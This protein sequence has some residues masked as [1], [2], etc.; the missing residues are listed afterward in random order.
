[1]QKP[2]L[3][4]LSAEFCAPLSALASIA[5]ALCL[6]LPSTAFGQGIVSA[7]MTGTLVD[8]AG[9][10]IGG[11]T[12]TAVHTPTNTTY[13]DI[14]GQNGRFSFTGMP[15][16]GP[17]TVSAVSGTFRIEP[18][19]DVETS[20]GQI[21]DV[22]LVAKEEVVAMEKFVASATRID[23]DG[24]ATGAATV[25]DSRQ[26]LAQPNGGRTFADLFKT[27]PFV[28]LRAF[29]QVE[30]L[31]I[32]SRYN[33]ITL[34]GAKINDSFGLNP[35]GLFSLNNPFSLD[36]IEQFSISLTPYDVRQSG[37][38]GAAMNA[39]SKSGT[40]EFHGSG[41]FV[42]TDHNW[43]GKD[44]SGSTVNTRSL[45][46]ERTYGFTF[47][48][49]I[50]KDR[51]FFFTNFEKYFR[52]S[53]GAT[54][55]GFT[56][57]AAFLDA[58]N[59]R[60]SALPGTPTMGTFGASSVSRLAD[61]KRMAKLDWN[62]TKD[63]RLSVRYS[64]T[65]GT[66]PTFGS[67]NAT[68]F[69]QPAALNNQPSSFTNNTT[70][71]T[72]N[73]YTLDVREKVWAAQLF[74]NWTS[75]FKTQFS[76]S[77]TKQDS[78]RAT[79]VK[80]PEI[81][82][83]NVPGVSS[84]GAT[85]SSGDSFRFGTETSSMGNELHIKTQTMSGSGDYTVKNLTFTGG[86]DHEVSD[87]LNLFRQGSYG[88]FDYWNLADFQADRPFGFARAVI[89][90]G[91]PVADVSRFK[92]TGIF[93]QVKWEPNSRLNA[94]L[95]VRLD[96]I[97]SPIAPPENAPFT[98]AFGVTN[99][100]TI[101]GTSNIEP[102][103]SFNY[104]LDSKRD[105]QVRGGL[106]VYLGRN[107]WVWISNSFG[108]TGVG[109]FNSVYST[110]AATTPNTAAYAGPTLT[111]YLNGSFSNSD[112]AY[113]FDPANPIGATNG[114]GTASS[115]NLIKPGL[116][117]PTVMRG[118][119]AVDHRLPFLDA[120]VSVEYIETNQLDALFVDNMNLRPTTVGI[121]G[122]QRF[123]G[124]ATN[125]P[126]VTNF[127]NV[128][129]TRDVR[130]GASQYTSI[131]L[132]RPFK[133]NWAYTVSLTHG[134][135][136]EAQTLNSSTANSQWQF[137]SVFNQNQVEVARS[138]YEIRDRVQ[139][140]MS[141]RFRFKSDYITTVSL[142]YEG[143]TGQPYSFVYANDFN[144]DGF[145]VNDLV[146]V[147]KS[148]TDPRFD[149]TGLTAAQQYAYFAFLEQSGLSRYGGSYAPRNSFTTEWQNRLD[150]RLV[151]ELPAYRQVKFEVFADFINFGAWLSHH[152]FNYIQ[153]IN[154][155]TGN[156]GLTRA[157]GAATY[158]ASNGLIKPTFN[159]GSTTVLVLDADNNLAFSGSST[160]VPNNGDSRWKITGGIRIKF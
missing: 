123:A 96:Y 97:G 91:L 140:S 155:S 19:T 37:F 40:N 98:N 65:L 148:L 2:F 35:S 128:I 67:Y 66:L 71:F 54:R 13:T 84:S 41:Y 133:N 53:L 94:T 130:K 31:G 60:L 25:L 151:Q 4:S 28:S 112:P 80:F 85:I 1:M 49:P 147:P 118:N 132:D 72:S 135:A 33:T 56:P 111:Q 120:T 159:N 144:N 87:Y 44:V 127:A 29:P 105:T 146:A 50:L 3:K 89:Q 77:N 15:V 117:L 39:V 10:P 126:L 69:S 11:A 102:R 21:T 137:N 36:A 122:R 82:I 43:G 157:F 22:L 78:V 100:G 109:R 61:T 119:I 81:R 27:N 141:R 153:E 73:F 83:M 86:A 7:G 51:L 59:T 142:Y 101:D 38:A 136:T 32:N 8:P 124:N 110:P 107:P 58:V 64:D 149:F 138:D 104:A 79:P 93:G 34:D 16:G 90:T 113:K 9:K 129:R 99:A 47:G 62:I 160:I 152:F 74:N 12:V 154:T 24:G 26:I 23:L 57:D 46:K 55:P 143:R 134:H 45:S 156:G 20:L 48:G 95:G 68:S 88:Y 42:F 17:Y 158:N 150:L 125:A 14:T 6:L 52:D 115:I 103:F 116:Q 145:T 75:D 5:L 108:N 30:A 70:S 121:D 92:E 18:R 139:L 106:G 76:Y 63:H 114:N 131:T